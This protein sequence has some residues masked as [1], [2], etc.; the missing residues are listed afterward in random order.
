MQRT[1]NFVV[2]NKQYAMNIKTYYLWMLF[3]S[4][5]PLKAFQKL[6]KPFVICLFSIHRLPNSALTIFTSACHHSK[7]RS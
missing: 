4:N 1:L 3:Q 2:V 7:T 5:K 6:S